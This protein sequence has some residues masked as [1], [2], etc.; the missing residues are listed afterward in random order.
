MCVCVTKRGRAK[1]E[2]GLLGLSTLGLS[3]LGL[4]Y[5]TS[6]TVFS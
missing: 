6:A 4:L 1:G 5:K 3:T 2:E